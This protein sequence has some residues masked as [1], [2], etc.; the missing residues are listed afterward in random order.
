MAFVVK[1]SDDNKTWYKAQ[2]YQYDA[3]NCAIDFFETN[4]GLTTPYIYNYPG[5]YLT[6]YKSL[7]EN[8]YMMI[9]EDKSMGYLKK[10]ISQYTKMKSP[11]GGIN[12]TYL[13][14]N[15]FIPEGD[16]YYF[17]NINNIITIGWHGTYNPPLDMDGN[18]TIT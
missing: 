6:I 15:I 10:E 5:I 2:E 7:V 11:Q 12:T 17:D 18:N 8:I 16:T 13:N 14:T 9:R 3:L 4:P 1:Y